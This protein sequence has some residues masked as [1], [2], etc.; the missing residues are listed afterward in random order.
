M[1][2]HQGTLDNEILQLAPD[3]DR[4]QLAFHLPLVGGF[5]QLEC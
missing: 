3:K 1:V 5:R 4:Q 2:F